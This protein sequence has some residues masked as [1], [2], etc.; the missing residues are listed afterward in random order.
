MRESPIAHDNLLIPDAESGVKQRVPNPLMEC[1]MQQLHNEL[2]ALPD[3]G[4][5]LGARYADTN[6]VIIIDTIICLL[7]PPQLLTMIDHHKMMYG[8]DVCNTSKYFQETLMHGG[9][10]N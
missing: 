2:I 8:F 4:G 3:D 7:A 5:L 10:E 6:D 1:S 9:G